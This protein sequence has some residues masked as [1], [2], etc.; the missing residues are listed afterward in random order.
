[1]RVKQEEALGRKVM[2]SLMLDGMN[3]KEHVFFD[4]SKFTGHVDFGDDLPLLLSDDR[5]SHPTANKPATH[6]LVLMVNAV[7]GH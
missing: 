2:V 6:A 1:M 5:P 4:N 3:I 7:N